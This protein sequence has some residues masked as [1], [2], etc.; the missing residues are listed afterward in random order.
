[1]LLHP[2]DLRGLVDM[3][4]AI[5]VIENAYRD[6]AAFPVVNVPRQRVHSPNNVR[7]STFSGGAPSLGVIGVAEHAE[8]IAHSAGTQ[9]T[10]AREHQVWVLHDSETSQLL[11]IMIGAINERTIGWEGV[12]AR[13]RGATTQTSL[14]TGA[15]SGVGFR[16]LAR[17]DAR[18]AGLIGSGNQAI[19]QI[20]ALKAVRPIETVK[21]YSSTPNNRE[22]FAAKV[23]RL[24]GLDMQPVASA[25]A[26]V[27]GVDVVIAAT[28]S[29]VPVFDGAWLEKGQHV[30]TI[31]GSN[32]ALLEGGW[33]SK[34][35]REIDNE[36]VARADVIVA[37][38]RASVMQDRQGDLYEPIEAR[39]ITPEDIGDLADLVAG[40]IPGRTSPD[41]ITLHKNNNGLGCA[42]M[43][44]AK[45]AYEKAVAAGRGRRMDLAK[46]QAG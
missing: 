27:R 4:D 22:E 6:V 17:A 31:V 28:N 23:G 34:S 13:T 2:E 10:G 18:T 26:A 1:M 16:H 38:S 21:V 42:E 29:N 46:V 20:Q 25:E 40:K 15:T 3:V 9:S 12:T 39:I 11:A 44:L 36:T 41:Q 43:A 24:L 35:R 30:V 8:R 7:V 37:N 32:A 14:R 5:E 45:L 19:T 33:L